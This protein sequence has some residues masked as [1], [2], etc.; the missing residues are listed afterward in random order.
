MALHGG[1]ESSGGVSSLSCNVWSW[2]YALD[3]GSSVRGFVVCVRHSFPL[4]ARCAW[5]GRSKIWLRFS[6]F[7]LSKV[8]S[9]NFSPNESN[10]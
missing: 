6:I 5:D 10:R 8:W 4:I 9:L 1:F 2:I 7:P 3:S